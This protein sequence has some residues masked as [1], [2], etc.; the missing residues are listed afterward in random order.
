M[1]SFIGFIEKCKQKSF[2]QIFT[3]YLR[4]LIG[5]AFVIAAFGMG[6]FNGQQLLISSPG[7]GIETLDPLQQF[8]RVMSTSGL[9]C[10]GNNIPCSLGFEL[11]AIYPQESDAGKFKRTT[12]TFNC[13]PFILDA[14]RHNYD[15]HD[16]FHGLVENQCCCSTG[17]GIQRRLT[18]IRHLYNFLEGKGQCTELMARTFLM[19]LR[20]IF[21]VPEES[22]LRNCFPYGF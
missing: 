1:D 18:G 5:G 9:Y 14:D 22:I 21:P 7:A 4:Y 3:I 10:P 8:F 2:L 11:A 15:R 19:G 20:T 16:Y 12:E 6:K 17:I 13:K